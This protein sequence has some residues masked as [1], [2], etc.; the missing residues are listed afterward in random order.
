MARGEAIADTVQKLRFDLTRHQAIQKDF[1]DAR[2]HYYNGFSSKDVN[3]KYTNWYFDRRGYA[4]YIAP[5]CEVN[6][7]FDGDDHMV[8]VHSSPMTSKLAYISWNKHNTI[9]FS[10]LTINLKTHAFKED[11]LNACQTEIMAFIKSKP[12]YK[13]DDKHLI[14]RLKKLIAFI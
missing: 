12:G 1:P 11:M 14:P 3:Q 13:I 10:R 4:V 7:N 2:Y 8:K 6:F 9:R 5:Y